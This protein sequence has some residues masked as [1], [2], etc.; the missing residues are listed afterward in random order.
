MTDNNTQ[1]DTIRLQK[2]ELRELLETG[3]R[4]QLVMEDGEITEKKVT[5]KLT[6]DVETKKEES[7]T[8]KEVAE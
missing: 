8:L 1:H 2:P 4:T 7:W 5:I 6:G 3:E